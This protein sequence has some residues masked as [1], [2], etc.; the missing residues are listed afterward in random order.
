MPYPS[1]TTYPAGDLYPGGETPPPEE[2][3]TSAILRPNAD[4]TKTAWD[5]VPAGAAYSTLDDD[6]EAPA[7]PSTAD[8]IETA[9]AAE[10]SKIRFQSFTPTRAVVGA[11]AWSYMKPGG[12]GVRAHLYTRPSGETLLK[13][14]SAVTTELIG[15]GANEDYNW[16]YANAGHVAGA[17]VLSAMGAS[18]ARYPIFWFNHEPTEGNYSWDVRS[19]SAYNAI[20][21][22]GMVPMV[23]VC[24][25][26]TWAS[27]TPGAGNLR[28]PN[29]AHI[30]SFVN[31]MEA[32]HAHL[33]EAML[34]VWNE[35]NYSLFGDGS[36][37]SHWATITNA[38]SE[39]L[40]PDT[41]IA[42]AM[43]PGGEQEA[44]AY[45][46]TMW[47]AITE[48]PYVKAAAHIY[49][50]GAAWQQDITNWLIRLAERTP[51]Q[52]WITECGIHRGLHGG[53]TNQ[54][55][56]SRTMYEMAAE[57]GIEGI[58]YH[59]FRSNSDN[60]AEVEGRYGFVEESLSG[61]NFVT[62]DLYETLT[63]TRQADIETTESATYRWVR[64]AYQGP[65][66][67]AEIDALEV[68][69]VSLGTSAS[70][71][72]E[73]AATYIVLD[74]LPL[75]APAPKP[76]VIVDVL[77]DGSLAHS[78]KLA[79]RVD[80]LSGGVKVAE[81]DTVL[82]GSVTLDARS[83]SR[84]RCEISLVDDGTMGLVPDSPAAL[85]APFGNELQIF[86]GVEY[87]TQRELVSLGI[88]GIERA[89]TEDTGEGVVISVSGLDRSWRFLQAPF[90]RPITI[91]PGTLVTNAI[92][93]I[94]A[95]AWASLEYAAGE[96]ASVDPV[97]LPLLAAQE[98]DDRWAFCQALAVS[99]GSEL[100]FDD[101]GTLRLVPTP[102]PSGGA[103]A[104]F[105]EGIDGVLLG[106]NRDWDRGEVYN[107]VV[108][109]GENP[110]IDGP[111]PRGEAADSDPTSPTYYDRNSRF[112]KKPYFYSNSWITTNAGAQKMARGL[113]ARAIGAPDV[114]NFGAIVD[115][116][117][118]PGDVVAIERPLSVPAGC[119]KHI[120]DSVT[121]PLA[122]EAEM[123]CATRV[124]QILATE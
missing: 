5:E 34:Q 99:I 35:P 63:D 36:S 124:A 18:H 79:T 75:A 58:I 116:A 95:D 92:L 77:R 9:V 67:Q 6:V 45:F 109:S 113:L 122:P 107:K 91:Q 53:A 85:L 26:P 65:L 13:Q 24:G 59:R 71:A 97:P 52:G 118:R 94:L 33:P 56:R 105:A 49:P 41:C 31:F 68:D 111:V 115:P 108:V 40:Q 101:T 8:R 100:F 50:S 15:F 4:G 80:V 2:Q 66:T 57:A 104:T 121:I 23:V 60:Q 21:A 81:L 123:S 82:E 61:A 10:V 47:N 90:E 22:A 25:A 98:G 110:N 76:D 72:A 20:L 93:I 83:A 62:N 38:V 87:G 30:T 103:S 120:L 3:A 73:V 69:F 86:R 55:N 88:F 78:H 14:G 12:V 37:A 32:L 106:V 7:A 117:R 28:V 43:S 114:I 16:W 96:F 17:P 11:T 29:V 70:P 27:N 102:E 89:G 48:E 39:A 84:G 44:S 46:N 51:G 119:E 54:A 74:L 64:T 19:D 42:P 112:G 1:P